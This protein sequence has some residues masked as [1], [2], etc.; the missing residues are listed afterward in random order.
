MEGVIVVKTIKLGKKEYVIIE[1]SE[2]DRILGEA[3]FQ[4]CTCK[5][6]AR[7]HKENPN[8][9]IW[10]DFDMNQIV[11]SAE[12]GRKQLQKLTRKEV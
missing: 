7:S 10:R 9:D 4:L 12:N 2:L 5:N 3:E 8:P 11:A 1:R 6:F